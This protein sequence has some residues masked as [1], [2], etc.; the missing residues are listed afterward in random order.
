MNLRECTSCKR[1]VGTVPPWRSESGR[2]EQVL[3]RT[4]I[5]TYVLDMNSDDEHEWHQQ[6]RPYVDPIEQQGEVI[7]E[8]CIL[9]FWGVDI[10]SHYTE[11]GQ[12][13]SATRAGPGD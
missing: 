7:C 13:A 6:T 11:D 3:Y 9:R 12:P 1:F 10:R 5:V 4:V 8:R 2:E